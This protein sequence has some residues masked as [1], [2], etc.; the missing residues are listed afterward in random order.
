M[1]LIQEAL[2]RVWQKSQAARLLGYRGMHFATGLSK[3][4]V[5]DWKVNKEDSYYIA[6]M[7]PPSQRELRSQKK[8]ICRG[9]RDER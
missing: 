1:R 7:T 6:A 8:N 9:L 2:R 4:G 3:L 5:P